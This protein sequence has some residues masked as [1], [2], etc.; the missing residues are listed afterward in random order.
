MLIFLL[1][2]I[3]IIPWLFQNIILFSIVNHLCY[4]FM[5]FFV[6][7]TFVRNINL[8]ALRQ[9]ECFTRH[10]ISSLFW[11]ALTCWKL[12]VVLVRRRHVCIHLVALVRTILN[13]II[14]C[15]IY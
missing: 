10:V 6:I 12:L 1:Y 11:Q 4:Y 7:Y 3:R 5:D 15:E 2:M 8:V 9:L 13:V 14:T